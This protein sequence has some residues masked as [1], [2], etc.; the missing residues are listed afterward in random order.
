M[1]LPHTG[2]DGA[3][4]LAERLRQAIAERQIPHA[5]RPQRARH[6]LVRRRRAA[7]RRD[8]ADRGDGGRGRRRLPLQA[9][10]QEPCFAGRYP[11]QGDELSADP[12][13]ERSMLPRGSSAGSLAVRLSKPRSDTDDRGTV[14][15]CLR[16]LRPVHRTEGGVCLNPSRCLRGHR[17]ASRAEA[18]E[19][20]SQSMSARCRRYEVADPFDNHALFKSESEARREEEETGELPS[21]HARVAWTGRRGPVRRGLARPQQCQDFDWGD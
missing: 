5:R 2:I 19:R 8:D 13:S 21:D 3:A 14:A 4:R 18:P 1:I 10:R 12:G 15:L 16:G 6:G 9:G 7:G 20:S 17:R 11:R